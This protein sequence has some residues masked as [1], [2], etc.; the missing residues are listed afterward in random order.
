[1]T[2]IAA[3]TALLYCGSASIVLATVFSIYVNTD[4][5]NQFPPELTLELPLLPVSLVS[6]FWELGWPSIS[7]FLKKPKFVLTHVETNGWSKNFGHFFD[8][9]LPPLRFSTGTFARD[10]LSRVS[11][12]VQS[13]YSPVNI[14]GQ[15]RCER[16]QECD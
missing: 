3:L 16:L 10:N 5:P 2:L 12:L 7:F 6:H 11:P 4:I 13:L 1:M 9:A 8:S 14:K 15:P